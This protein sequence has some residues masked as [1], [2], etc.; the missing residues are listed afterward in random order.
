MVDAKDLL[1]R[2]NGY[3]EQSF[4]AIARQ[5]GVDSALQLSDTSPFKVAIQKLWESNVARWWDP[6][7]CW[8]SC[9]LSAENWI[10]MHSN[11]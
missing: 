1:Q 8:N 7:Y 4:V 9:R 10:S 5:Q 6:E 11:S 2:S 3:L